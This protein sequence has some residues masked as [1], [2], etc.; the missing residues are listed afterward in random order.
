METSITHLKKEVAFFS[1]IFEMYSYDDRLS[2][3]KFKRIIKSLGFLLEENEILECFKC[4]SKEDVKKI[5]DVFPID[6]DNYL[7]FVLEYCD[8]FYDDKEEIE[9]CFKYLANGDP[10]EI[11]EKILRDFLVEKGDKIDLCYY[12]EMLKT[13]GFDHSNETHVNYH[14]LIDEIFK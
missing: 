13:I 8:V 1:K 12:E 9:D 14:L 11:E 7:K 5:E 2:I 10:E 3:Q 4:I 6:F